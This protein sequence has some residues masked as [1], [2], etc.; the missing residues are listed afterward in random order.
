M[1]GRRAKTFLATKVSTD[2]SPAHIREAIDNSLRALQTDYVDLYQIHGWNPR[3]PIE[4]SMAT[5]EEL[6]RAGQRV[7]NVSTIRV[8]PWHDLPLRRCRSRAHCRP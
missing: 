6:R 7:C 1:G 2:Y 3:C 5:M 8:A 4:E